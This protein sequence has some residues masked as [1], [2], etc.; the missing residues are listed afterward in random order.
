MDFFKTLDYAVLKP[1]AT[2]RDLD[3]AIAI[4]KR[5]GVG[6]LCVKPCHVTYAVEQLQG[7][8]TSVSAVVDF[9]H[10][11][12]VPSIKRLEAEQ[13][14][15]DG[16]TEVDMVLNIAALK[17]GDTETVTRE[18][19]A[20]VLSLAE[21]NVIVKVIL[22]TALLTPDEIR[23]GVACCIAAGAAFAKTSTGFASGG[24]TPEA[25]ALMIEEAAG[26]IQVKA[27]GG[28]RDRATAEHYLAL[29]ATRLGVGNVLCLAT[30]Q[31]K[32]SHQ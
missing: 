5:F 29:G 19:S 28:I 6:N 23:L 25:V 31:E 9:P 11:H 24:A 27:S 21:K 22:E 4:C 14:A 16:A 12:A 1:D 3:E 17:E 2:H 8:E 30:P 18:I 7:T 13:A 20:I 15:Q 26:R 10:G 32:E